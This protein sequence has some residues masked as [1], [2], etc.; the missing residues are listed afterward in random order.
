[1][2]AGDRRRGRGR[3]L[4]VVVWCLCVSAIWLTGSAP[5]AS[6]STP[7]PAPVTPSVTVFT[8]Q[9]QSSP[10]WGLGVELDP[11]DALAPAQLNWP[12]ITQRL[13]FM[14]P[15]FLRVV[16][17]ASTYFGGY[18]ASGNPTYRW[19]APSMQEL[20]SI[21]GY[22]QAR[23]I[24]VVLGGLGRSPDPGRRADPGRLSAGAARQL[25]VLGGAVLQRGQ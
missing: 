9:V 11:Y 21:L 6:A 3:L 1:M 14:S 8:D 20:L 10:F 23:G 4:G 12:L 18:D 13:D 5:A 7:V 19:T 17:P 24:P 16:E 2:C 15:G 25:R 22:A